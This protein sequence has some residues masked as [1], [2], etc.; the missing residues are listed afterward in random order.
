MA[1]SSIKKGIVS[2][3]YGAYYM[4]R[5]RQNPQIEIRTVL[6]G[7][8]R[9]EKK[10][11]ENRLQRH[12]LMAGDHVIYSSGGD[13]DPCIEE[14]EPRHNSLFRASPFE[15]HGLGANLDRAI[16][17]MSLDSPPPRFG[18]LDRFLAS[19][20]F[21]N[22][23]P[24]IVFTKKD[25]Y[26][27]LEPEKR[28][29]IEE[30]IQIYRALDIPVFMLPLLADNLESDIEFQRLEKML[31]QGTTLL[32]GNSGTG[33]STLLNR[34][35][36]GEV[37]KTGDVSKSSG[38]GKHTTTNSALFIHK[39]GEAFLI[40]TPGVKEWGINHM[41]REALFYSFPELIL[42]KGNCR[43]RNCDHSEGV[44]G[45]AI[46]E[47]IENSLENET[48]PV[49]HPFRIKSLYSMIESL[50]NPD[51]IRTGDYIKPTGRMRKKNPGD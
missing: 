4:V 41:N 10:R 13:D 44:D 43:F 6:R 20:E 26:D 25:L 33:K 5:D 29:D 27:E 31:S 49:I 14:I 38:K 45:C 34:L 39:N 22:V 23:P 37:Q 9:L 28:E 51:R 40:D 15:H 17:V 21:G 46:Q 8:L 32:A 16:V 48:D 50:D 3:V 2:L 47:V 1:E 19:C 35:L 36:S 42:F 11:E 24:V 12:L 18:F 7:K 30:Y